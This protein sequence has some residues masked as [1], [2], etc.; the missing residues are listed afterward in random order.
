MLVV[1]LFLLSLKKKTSCRTANNF[2]Q[3]VMNGRERIS[4]FFFTRKV[5]L[6]YFSIIMGKMDRAKTLRPYSPKKAEHEKEKKLEK[7]AGE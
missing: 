1:V 6:F 4:S 3:A 7:K 2:L 5:E